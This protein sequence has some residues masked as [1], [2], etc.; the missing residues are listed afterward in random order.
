MWR[1]QGGWHARQSVA[2][3]V[4]AMLRIP[5]R[6]R[7]LGLSSV[8]AAAALAVLASPAAGQSTATCALNVICEA[9]T[10]TL[11]DGAG[12]EDEHAG[13]TG[14]G[15]RRPAVRRRGR[16]PDS[17]RGR[18][19]NAP[20]DRSLC[21]R[22]TGH[23]GREPPLTLT[24]NGTTHIPVL[25]PSTASWATWSTVTALAAH[26]RINE[27]DLHTVPQQRADH[28]DH[29]VARRRRRSPAGR[30]AADLQHQHA[31]CS[32]SATSSGAR[33]RTWMRR[34]RPSTASGRRPQV[35]TPNYREVVAD[36]DIEQG[37]RL[38]VPAAQRRRI[39]AAHRRPGGH[40]PRW[41]PRGH[42]QGRRCHAHR[43]L[44]RARDPLPPGRRRCCGSSCSGAPGPDDVRD[45][46]D[47]RVL[48]R[49]RRRP[50]VAPGV[51]ECANLSDLP[52]D[53]SPLTG[54]HPSFTLSNLR[55]T[56]SGPTCRESPGTPTAARPC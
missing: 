1:G 42:D 44:A 7:S 45:R 55:P 34:G 49:R 28:I 11:H 17:Q 32:S 29:I 8:A 48:G 22:G 43:R 39:Q 51:K 3:R 19:R 5:E 15:L 31:R 53:G 36:L 35:Y 41:R 13:Y 26:R 24:V 47:V 2:V 50:V 23:R 46:P 25:F 20:G 37:R 33:R 21:E 38:Y 30:D 4:A 54:V 6:A 12:T 16:R 10:G 52:G 27:L 14:T 40:R 9:E 56:R 18:S